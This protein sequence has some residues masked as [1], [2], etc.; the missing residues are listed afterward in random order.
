MEVSRRS[1]SVGSGFGRPPHDG[2]GADDLGARAEL[3]E[4]PAVMGW[5]LECVKDIMHGTE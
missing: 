2:G 4:M 5:T 1:A 3:G